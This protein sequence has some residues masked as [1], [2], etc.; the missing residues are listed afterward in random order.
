LL[1]G[2]RPGR[3]G[4]RVSAWNHWSRRAGS[5]RRPADYEEAGAVR[6]S[7]YLQLLLCRERHIAAQRCTQDGPTAPGRPLSITTSSEGMRGMAPAATPSLSGPRVSPENRQGTASGGVTAKRTVIRLVLAPVAGWLG[8]CPNR[9]R[10]SLASGPVPYSSLSG[11]EPS[12]VTAPT[13]SCTGGMGSTSRGKSE[14]GNGS[15]AWL[16]VR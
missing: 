2:G 16:Y 15:S 8:H 3:R 1:S 13:S 6:N 4:E 5:N 12:S 14:N 9:A 11:P 7:A 10:R